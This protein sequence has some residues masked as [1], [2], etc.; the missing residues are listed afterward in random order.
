MS[1]P[2]R[3]FRWCCRTA[4]AQRL[5][6][7]L[8]LM[9]L[10][11]LPG[12]GC[13]PS[14][15]ILQIAGLRSEVAALQITAMLNGQGLSAG[16]V[17][18]SVS[19]SAAQQLGCS[20]Q[21]DDLNKLALVVPEPAGELSVALTAL[22]AT[23]CRLAEASSSPQSLPRLPR[24]HT[25]SLT[26]VRTRP[27]PNCLPG[28]FCPVA[29]PGDSEQS[30]YWDLWDPS[31]E[32]VW[33]AGSR[34]LFRHRC[35]QLDQQPDPI[36]PGYSAISVGGL[37]QS[38]LTATLHSDIDAQARDYVLVSNGRSAQPGPDLKSSAPAFPK[39]ARIVSFS[40][41]TFYAGTEVAGG[42]AVIERRPDG[43]LRPHRL[44]RSLKVYGIWGTAR[45]DVWVVGESFSISRFDGQTFTQSSTGVTETAGDF[46]GVSGSSRGDVWVVGRRID[47][48]QA[49]AYHRV[50]GTWQPITLDASV[51]DLASVWVEPTGRAWLAG[52][53]CTVLQFDPQLGKLSMGPTPP[54]CA[55][56]TDFK[57][58]WGKPG[59]PLWLLGN[60]TN[61]GGT[62]LAGRLFV[63]YDG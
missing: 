24:P 52:R 34:G 62:E 10:V 59:G 21:V 38:M 4:S 63:Y 11:G 6:R 20:R 30:T 13:G 42:P 19:D 46:Y 55:A 31:G 53:N 40:D 45:D 16:R 54:A 60:L 14:E 29:T 48:A 35:G 33:V 43:T 28:T 58:I 17:C 8:S 32:S 26:L 3:F 9:A 27:L 56:D 5:F 37:G 2:T 49:V 1:H 25:L 57:R 41:A 23:G 18:G 51:T 39:N 50:A 22:D 36:D 47:R 15:V 44:P 12:M 7:H 61:S